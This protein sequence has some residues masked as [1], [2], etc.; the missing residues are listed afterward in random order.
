MTTR[1]VYN[2]RQA[3]ADLRNSLEALEG[4]LGLQGTE[5]L[6]ERIDGA[7]S[8][9]VSG[10]S[11]QREAALAE[12]EERLDALGERVDGAVS[13][14]FYEG[15]PSMDRSPSDFWTGEDYASHLGD[16]YYDT[17]TGYCYRF[18]RDAEEN[19]GWVLVR[20]TGVTRA[21]SLAEAAQAAASGAVQTQQGAQKAGRHLHIDAQ[22]NVTSAPATALML[23]N[24]AG[25]K[26]FVLS[27]GDDGALSVSEVVEDE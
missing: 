24:S 18:Q 1:L 2:Y 10:E 25:T 16:L 17:Q 5:S 9:A 7:V 20:D 27:V 14:Y 11:T 23:S 21:L 13:T 15:E 3:D 26:T 22:G 6:Q 12:V 4:R 19:Y 8:M